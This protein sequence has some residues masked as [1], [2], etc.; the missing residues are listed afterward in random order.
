MQ[1]LF[2]K[3]H[4]DYEGNVICEKSGEPDFLM[5]YMRFD[6]ENTYIPFSDLAP[7][8]CSGH[9]LLLR[10]PSAAPVVVCFLCS[11]RLLLLLRRRLLLRPPAAA[12]PAPSAAPAAG[13]CCS[14]AVCCSGRRR[15]LPSPSFSFVC[16]GREKRG[17]WRVAEMEMHLLGS[18]AP[19]TCFLCSGDLL[20]LLPSSFSFVCGGGEK[21]GKVRVGGSEGCRKP[22]RG[23]C[24]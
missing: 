21:R 12:A 24:V 6:D 15:L 23:F 20:P 1:K 9:L 16:G 2:S 7:A 4:F 13:C 8:T 5:R 18:S 10:P 11:G 3:L 19:A 22:E 14:G 17:K